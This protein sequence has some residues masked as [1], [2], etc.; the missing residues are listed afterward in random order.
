MALMF[1]LLPSLPVHSYGILSAHPPLDGGG[2]PVPEPPALRVLSSNHTWMAGVRE[3]VRS[4]TLPARLQRPFAALVRS[5]D[6]TLPLTLPQAA[7]QSAV[8]HGCPER[9]P[10]SVTK[11]SAVPPSG[12]RHDFAYISTYAWPCNAACPAAYRTHCDQ[13]WRRP[14]WANKTSPYP[15]WGKCDNATGLPWISHDG[16]GQPAG[17]HDSQCSD[18]MADALDV[19][20]TAFYFT[21]NETYGKVR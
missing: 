18:R 6:S 19:L 11:K 8:P 7:G 15:D 4:G 9:G 17:Q 13:W 10:W 3:K 16:F 21:R 2:E 5:A 14:A 20:A 1:L 12:D